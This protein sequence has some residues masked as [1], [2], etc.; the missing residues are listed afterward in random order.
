MLTYDMVVAD[1]EGQQ[2][3]SAYAQRDASGANIR[4]F[5]N[6]G[7]RLFASHLSFT[8]LDGNGTTPYA[9]GTAAQTGLG[10]AATW[11][12]SVYTDGSGT[13][14]ISIG[15]PRAS[16]RIQTFAAWSADYGV[17]TPPSTSFTIT[18]PRSTATSIGTAS[19]EFVFRQDGNGRQQQF[20]FNTP[21]AAPAA[22]ACGRVAYSGFH[23]AATGGG[24]NPFA[25]SIFPNHCGGD[26][27][28]QEKVLLYM[29]FDLGAC[30]GE[31]PPPPTCTPLACKPG[32]CGQQPNGCG[33]ALNCGACPPNCKPTTCDAQGAECGSI[34]DSCG[35][36]LDCGPCPPGKVCG[37]F[38]PNKCGSFDCKKRTCEDAAAECGNIGD[39]CGGLV[40]CGECPPGEVCGLESPNKCTPPDCTATTCNEQDAE[41]GN[42]GDGCGNVIDCGP[43]PPGKVCGRV[44][45]NQCDGIQ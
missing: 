44:R 17:V 19:E 38:E 11:D 15:R 28:A 2:Y 41:C 39:G 18:D 10:P 24:T 6:R 12:N 23:V 36:V 31:L 34:G 42:I 5:V 40:D 14:V 1:C 4:E 13:G 32:Q 25:T 22:A 35:K 21:Y 9:A 43:C 26:L 29:L 8:W 33:G 7:G 37:A 20:S 27:T 3:D 16:P 30:V 45:A